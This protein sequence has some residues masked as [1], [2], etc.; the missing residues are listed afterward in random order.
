M[1]SQVDLQIERLRSHFDSLGIAG[2]KQFI[3]NLQQKL[4][5]SNS[6]EYKRF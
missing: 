4:Q 1:A 3:V 6:I 2:K 5:G